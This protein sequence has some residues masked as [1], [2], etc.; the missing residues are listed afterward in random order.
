MKETWG[1]DPT[2]EDTHVFI[3]GNPR[4]ISDM[5]ETLE[6]DGFTEWHKSKNPDGQIHVEKF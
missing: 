3:C 1:A 2:P 5:I 4:M 6:K